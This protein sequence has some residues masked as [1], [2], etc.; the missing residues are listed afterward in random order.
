MK[1]LLEAMEIKTGSAE[2]EIF[3]MLWNEYRFDD[4]D[5]MAYA[6]RKLANGQ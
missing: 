6:A 4:V 2:A 3:I 5:D 1:E